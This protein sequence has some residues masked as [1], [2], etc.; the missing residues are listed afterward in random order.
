M[1]IA[2]DVVTSTALADRICEQFGVDMDRCAGITIEL[3]PTEPIQVSL[4]LLAGEA[5]ERIDWAGYLATAQ[6]VKVQ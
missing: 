6:V 1:T 2:Y 3:L 4:K 5:L